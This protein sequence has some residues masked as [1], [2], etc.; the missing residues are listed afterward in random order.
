MSGI[1]KNYEA[2]QLLRNIYKKR[3]A[4]SHKGDFGTVLVIGGS[5]RL[6]GS[7]IFNAMAALR[8][9]ADLV[10]LIGNKRAM[11]VASQYMPDLIAEPLD[12]EFIPSS[13]SPALRRAET[14]DSV[15]IGGSLARSAQT[16]QAIC[17]FIARCTRPMVIDA[18]AIRA[19]GQKIP[20]LKSKKIVLTPHADEF[21]ALT[22]VR[23]RPEL[24]HRKEKVLYA[25]K[26][27]NVII[28]LKG[29]IDVISDG[30]HTFTNHTG[31][32][33]MTKGGFGDTLAGIC[34]TLLARGADPLKAACAA[35]YINGKAGEYASKKFGEGTLASDIF[36]EIPRVIQASSGQRGAPMV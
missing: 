4:W 1:K 13:V 25:A 30:I 9:G 27:Y 2:R 23:V 35:A 3:P 6:T 16:Y 19:I 17:T 5:N 21:Y 14:V 15:I 8:S 24:T 33:Y 26:K 31:T 18:E 36:K 11:N 22:G 12:G 10:Y 32:P 29:A 20:T 28:L 34:G 7:P